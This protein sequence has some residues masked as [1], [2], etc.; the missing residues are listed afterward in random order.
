MDFRPVHVDDA[1]DRAHQK[2][3]HLVVVLGDDHKGGIQIVQPRTTGRTVEVE[4]W[5][6]AAADVR[7]TPHHRMQLGHGRQARTLQHFLDLENVDAIELIASQAK[8]QQFES[9]L[10]N[11][12]RTLID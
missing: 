10:P 8:Q 12:L 6:G 5:Q 11:Q 4:D 3:L 7:D 9:V 1:L 2:A